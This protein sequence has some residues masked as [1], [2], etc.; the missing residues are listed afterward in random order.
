MVRQKNHVDMIIEQR[1]YFICEINFPENTEMDLKEKYPPSEPCSCEIC[2]NFCLRPGW[3]TVEEADKAIQ[4]GYAGRMMLEIS[5]ER[6]FGVLSPAFK[7]NESN[8]ALQVFS[9]NGC[10]FYNNELCDLFGTG[11]QPLECRFCHHDRKG[12]GIKCHQDLEKEW[13][14]NEAKRLIVKWGNMIGF[15]QRQGFNLIEK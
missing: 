9:K 11:L 13:K 5:P 4:A 2:K 8:Y 7:G 12:L 3:W 14:T 10:S 1:F 6:D 15:W